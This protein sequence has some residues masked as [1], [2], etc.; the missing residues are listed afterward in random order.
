MNE[1]VWLRCFVDAN[2]TV[3]VPEIRKCVYLLDYAHD[4]KLYLQ[5][6]TC[7]TVE[8]LKIIESFE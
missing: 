2:K 8:H 7:F 3:V 1:R 6:R 5:S 4:Q